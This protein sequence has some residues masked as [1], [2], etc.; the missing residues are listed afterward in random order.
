MLKEL[1]ARVPAAKRVADE[2]GADGPVTLA[3]YSLQW[4]SR[5]RERGVSSA[6]DDETR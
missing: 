5:R 1:K 4:A 2:T 3:A 6:R